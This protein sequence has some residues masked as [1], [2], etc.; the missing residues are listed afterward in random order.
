MK[1]LAVFTLSK[2]TKIAIRTLLGK[3]FAGALLIFL[4]ATLD[5]AHTLLTEQLM[6]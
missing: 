1:Q 5:Q 4:K 3:E 2:E 6:M